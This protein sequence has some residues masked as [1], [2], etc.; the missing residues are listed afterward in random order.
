MSFLCSR[1]C[2]TK[3]HTEV[4]FESNKPLDL[5]PFLSSKRRRA[6]SIESSVSSPPT[7]S[8]NIEHQS[9]PLHYDLFAVSNHMGSLGGGH[10]TATVKCRIEKT[11]KQIEWQW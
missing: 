9:N 2:R 1:H 4:L 3:N 10:Y 11:D 6:H 5:G 7:D 8:L